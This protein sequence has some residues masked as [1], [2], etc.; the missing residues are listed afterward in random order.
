MQRLALAVTIAA[1]A[2]AQTQDRPPAA[3]A[4]YKD[5]KFPPLP[6]VKI[7]EPVTFTLPNGM[8]IY[9]LEY[10]EL[11]L[12]HGVAIVRTGNLFD[13]PDKRGLAELTGSVL[14]SGGTR[15]KTGDELD[16]QLENIAASVE[17]SISE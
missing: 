12:V 3:V 2:V 6:P 10:H 4:S 14:R 13:P 7:P 16:V 5:L 9:L 11:P 15:D 8:K 17:S 1:V